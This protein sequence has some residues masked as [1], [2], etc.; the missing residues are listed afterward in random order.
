MIKS[1]KGIFQVNGERLQIKAELAFLINRL[2]TTNILTHD[3][4]LKIVNLGL[5]S[6]EELKNL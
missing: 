3:E 6:E 5:L 4:I 2:Y 1:E